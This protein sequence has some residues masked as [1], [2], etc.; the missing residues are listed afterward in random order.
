[1]ISPSWAYDQRSDI[2][3][4]LVPVPAK[5]LLPSHSA[6][7]TKRVSNSQFWYFGPTIIGQSP[8]SSD[9]SDFHHPPTLGGYALMNQNTTIEATETKRDHVSVISIKKGAFEPNLPISWTA[10]LT[11]DG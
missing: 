10:P 4:V 8:P 1:M 11:M 7:N 6:P 5:I 2:P 3:L 9:K